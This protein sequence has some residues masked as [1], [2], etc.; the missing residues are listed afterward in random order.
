MGEN[1][2]QAERLLATIVAGKSRV[3]G[4]S[5]GLSFEAANRLETRSTLGTTPVLHESHGLS[6]IHISE[7]TRPY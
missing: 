1:I 4:L 2:T 6:L 7:P 5:S 3:R